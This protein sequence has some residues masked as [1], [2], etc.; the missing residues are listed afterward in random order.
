MA[1][2]SLSA[3][4]TR[5]GRVW[6]NP[7]LAATRR[8]CAAERGEKAL[9]SED[10]ASRLTKGSIPPT[11]RIYPGQAH[12]VPPKIAGDDCNEEATVSE[13]IILC[14]LGRVG[15]RVLEFLQA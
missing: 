3:D 14:G 1:S 2:F 7:G 10:C 6:P 15:W 13:P 4:Y 11:S 8:L 12:G 5:C 9:R